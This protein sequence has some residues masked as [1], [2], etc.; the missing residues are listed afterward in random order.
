[1]HF[2]CLTFGVRRCTLQSPSER[3]T[4]RQGAPTMTNQH[5]ADATNRQRD[6]FESL[7]AKY[8]DALAVY[9]TASAAVKATGG[10]GEV[11]ATRTRRAAR[12]HAKRL[13]TILA[14][15]FGVSLG[16]AL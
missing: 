16:S 2:F 5:E 3:M 13:H 7:W 15:N 9:E 1:M 6:R 12:S 14:R 4:R 10:L 11:G 8:V